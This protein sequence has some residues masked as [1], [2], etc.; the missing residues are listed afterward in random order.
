MKEKLRVLHLEDDRLQAE[1]ARALLAE[2]E[3]DC[4]LAI[5]ETEE[6]FVSALD[7]RQFDMILAD[8]TLPRFNGMMALTM[9]RDQ[10]PDLPFIFVT[11]TMGEE[12]A[13]DA[14]RRGAT[15]YVLKN[16]LSRLAPAVRRAL[17]ESR[18][19]L[20]RK[21]S[22]EALR[23]SEEKYRTLVNNIS[24]G[25][26]M[27]SP[28]MEILSLN[29]QMQQWFPQ[30]DVSQRH[31]CHQEF[32]DPPSEEICSYCP[33][34]K[35]LQDG[36]RHEA[37]TETPSG[38]KVRHF[39]VNTFPLKDK[40]GMVTAVIEM[41]ED[42][43]ERKQAEEELRHSNELFRAL[44]QASPLAIFLLNEDGT[45]RIWNPAAERIFGWS[46]LE[47]L[48]RRLPIVPDDKVEEFA[49]TCDWVLKGQLLLRK[50]LQ[51]QRKDG[52]LIDIS[53]HAAPVYDAGGKASSI[54]AMVADITERKRVDRE[55]LQ[56]EQKFRTAFED[57]AVGMCL[58]GGDDRFL[59]V[60]YSL[61]KMLGYTAEEL[62]GM[63]WIEV[64]HPDD[65]EK[66][67]RW[68]DEIVA[69]DV[70]SPALE[71]RYIHR[72]GRI[73]WGMLTKVLLRDDS[74][75]PLYFIN[76]V[77]DITELKS[78]ENQ[79]RQAQKMEAIGTLAGGIAHDFNNILTAIIGYGSLLEMKIGKN[80]PS[81]QLVEHILT[82]ADR[83]ASLTKS[84]LTFGREQNSEQHIVDLSG[85]V[86]GVEKFLL[87]LL[88]EDIELRTTIVDKAC[89][90]FA[91]SGQIEQVLMNL[92]TNARDAM[93]HGGKLA[94]TT[95]MINLDRD[96][97][98]THGYGSP[99]RFALL[100]VTDTGAGMDAETKNR[101]FEPFFTTKEVG[102]GTGLGLSMAYG[103]V[104]QHNGYITCYSEPGEGTTFRVYLPAVDAL[105]EPLPVPSCKTPPG[106]TET[107]LVAEDDMQVRMLTH[108][109]LESFGYT[110]IEAVNGED[111]L[112]QFLAHQKTI[113]L[114]L[115]DV[116][117]PRKNGREAY[118]EM[119]KR[120]PGLK[121]LFTSGY[122]ADIFQQ[123]EL[124]ESSYA[125]ISKPVLPAE[126]L[127]KIRHMLDE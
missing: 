66:C 127:H 6:D 69:G 89:M 100:S 2:D 26:T 48:G 55:L 114:A 18:E 75:A 17:R 51:R 126:L 109:L 60:N 32:N 65:R 63:D 116:I 91:D 98:A 19:R 29:N 70:Y 124:D 45:V 53:L 22:E 102:K 1:L 43:S 122:S 85:I 23:R 67:R 59:I 113:Q 49:L 107:I 73:V 13:I 82:A 44:I 125:F 34:I 117:M 3:I 30:I 115:L 93:Q 84:L 25:I 10:Y 119:R 15:D 92:T 112:K 14:M 123:G 42:I 121:A 27:L 94:V 5:V 21:Q 54:L 108:K 9:V 61:C 120:S 57:A 64:T 16:R 38:G 101:I 106:G 58:T 86:L 35:S 77:Q 52:V 62:T 8:F 39:K 78:L 83:A 24:V 50:E 111:A 46:E 37:V 118:E 103:I 90:V 97:V 104:K 68:E 87:R 72:E 40:D 74:G 4:D 28:E 76:Q 56:S 31:L 71:K 81:L 105:A 95:S 20:E 11:G 88:R 36:E 80:D 7:S 99:G 79:L 96:F 12:I 110:V 47:V 41:A 33:V